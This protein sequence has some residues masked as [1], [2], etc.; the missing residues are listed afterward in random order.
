[1]PS[2]KELVSLTVGGKKPYCEWLV[3]N[4]FIRVQSSWY[5]SS[6]TAAGVVSLLYIID[7]CDGFVIHGNMSEGCYVWPVRGRQQGI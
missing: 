4:G 1:M 2:E 3:R 6:F 5:W 7:M